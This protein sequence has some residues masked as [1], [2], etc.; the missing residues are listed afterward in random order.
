MSIWKLVFRVHAENSP[1]KLNKEKCPSKDTSLYPKSLY[2]PSPIAESV[3]GRTW[4]FSGQDC[5]WSVLCRFTVGP[6]GHPSPMSLCISA[7]FFNPDFLVIYFIL[8]RIYRKYIILLCVCSFLPSLYPPGL[9]WF[10]QNKGLTGVSGSPVITGLRE[11]GLQLRRRRPDAFHW[12][13]AAESAA[14]PLPSCP[15]L[16]I[17]L[18]LQPTL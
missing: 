9:V 11:Q 18:A 15:P 7:L 13:L 17:Q 2:E 8:K 10:S 4:S 5:V 6:L 16:R 1:K 12:P 3:T 14:G